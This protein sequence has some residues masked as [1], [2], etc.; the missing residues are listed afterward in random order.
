MPPPCAWSTRASST[1]APVRRYLPRFSGGLKNQVTI[2]MLLDHTSGLKSYVPMYRKARGH[3]SRMIDLLY[4][5]PLIR[6]PGDSAEYSDLNAMLLGLVVERVGG[7]SLDRVARREVWEPLGMEQTRFRMPARLK[8]RTVPS[9]I[10]R[11]Q[12]VPGDVNDQNAAAMGGVSGHAGVFSTARDLARFAQVWLRN[13]LGPDGIWVRP[14]TMRTFLS[15]SPNSGSR[16]L[17]WDTPEFDGEDPSIFGTLISKAAYGHTGFTGTQVW[18][19]PT[20]NLFLVFLTN[21]TFDPKARDSLKGLKAIRTSLSD[22]AI[23]LVRTPA[24]RS[25]CRIAEPP[26]VAVRWAMR[27]L[28]AVGRATAPLGPAGSHPDSSR[29]RARDPARPARDPGCVARSGHAVRHPRRT[30]LPRRHGPARPAPVSARR[31]PARA[32]LLD[33]R[34]PGDRGSALRLD[35]RPAPPIRLWGQLCPSVIPIPTTGIRFQSMEPTAAS[36]APASPA[37]ETVRKALRAVKDPELNLNII[38][39]GLVYDVERRRSRRRR[40]ANDP[41]LA[42]LSRGRRDHRRRQAGRGRPRRGEERGGGAGVG[43][44]LDAGADGPPGSRLPRI[45]TIAAR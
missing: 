13:G 38:D 25:W 44:L 23:R 3:R 10:W 22:A 41:A 4:A 40:G 1:D 36:P 45:L 14:A 24:A 37:A 16:L 20:N 32:L 42:R 18:I 17:G 43:S 7:A 6:A 12:P 30:G 26:G 2:R 31:T 35:L 8:P 15:K 21:R 9:G 29:G 27:L 33:S 19:D 28:P 11:G 5:Q 34:G 39:I